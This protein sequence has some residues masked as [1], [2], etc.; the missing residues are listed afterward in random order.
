MFVRSYR[1]D[2]PKRGSEIG[3]LQN[4]DLV[5]VPEIIVGHELG[6]TVP[7][8]DKPG[9]VSY[10]HGHV[11]PEEI[12]KRMIA[13]G[14]G[15]TNLVVGSFAD[16]LKEPC[17]RCGKAS[18]VAAGDLYMDDDNGY[19]FIVARLCGNCLLAAEIAWH[20]ASDANSRNWQYQ[21]TDAMYRK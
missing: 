5:I 8:P 21:V 3:D 20:A 17:G 18:P 13:H 10:T 16:V 19:R 11:E 7:N 15:A 6:I 14:K 4:V 2:V 9:S 1:A 12:V